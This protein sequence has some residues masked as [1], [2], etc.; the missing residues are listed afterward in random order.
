MPLADDTRPRTAAAVRRPG[1]RS[2]V[3]IMTTSHA[4]QHF[5]NA[6][7]AL[8]Y[9]F[10]VVE[11]HISYAV[12]GLV[13]TVAG[14]LGGV[15]QGA[16][17]LVRRTSAR[18]I[19]SAQNVGLALA[20]LLGAVAP[21]FAVFAVARCAGAVVSWPQH[22]VGSAYLSERFPQRRGTVLSWHTVGGSIGTV[23]VPLLASVVIATA[24]WR[25]ALVA[26]A[27]PMALGGLLVALRLPVESHRPPDAAA[28]PDG[29]QPARVGLR[30]VLTRRRVVLVLAASTIAAGGRGLGT[31][32][33]Y[34]PAYLRSGLHLGP[35]TVGLVFTVIVAASVIGPVLIGRLAD[36]FGHTGVLVLTYL[37]GAV[38]LVAFGSLGAHVAAL[39]AVGI[40]VGALAYAESPLLQSVFAEVTQDGNSRS[41]FGAYFAISYGVGSLWLGVLGWVIDRA[42]FGAAFAVMAGSFVV[43]AALL[44]FARA[45]A[46]RRDVS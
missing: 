27:V 36:R 28:R 35:I 2:A 41:V 6:G 45:D 9:P 21:G 20:S 10:V 40:A 46:T 19:L 23:T 1:D 30:S 25:W 34:V 16:A 8:V 5:Y 15:L 4:V 14:V 42:G 24:G 12:L 17:G 39:I 11:F 3:A 38:A 33:T 43:A 26:I 32:S 7:L 44:P 22:P 18:L 13:L 37:A 29:P 31:L